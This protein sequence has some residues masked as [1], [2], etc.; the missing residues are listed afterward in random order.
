[1]VKSDKEGLRDREGRLLY[2]RA[3]VK[4]EGAGILLD[5][6]VKKYKASWKKRDEEEADRNEKLRKEALTVALNLK[7]ILVRDYHAKK[8]ILFGSVIQP[9]EFHSRSDIDIAVEG[10]PKDL[11]FQ[12]LGRL[13][14]ASDFEV[15]LKPIEDVSGLI[16]ER[17]RKGKVIYEEGKD[18]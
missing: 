3:F 1:M 9:G 17:I 8:V 14:F 15:D 11:H 12:A 6:E 10:L 16:A 13:V 18:S 2:Q 5:E 7:E 4:L